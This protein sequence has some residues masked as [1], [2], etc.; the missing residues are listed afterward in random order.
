[1]KY[2]LAFLVLCSLSVQ[3]QIVYDVKTSKEGESNM[4]KLRKNLSN[5]EN[6]FKEI[7]KSKFQSAIPDSLKYISAEIGFDF[8]VDT[9]GAIILLYPLGGPNK[10]LDNL[11]TQSIKDMPRWQVINEDSNI[12]VL[13]SLGVNFP[14]LLVLPNIVIINKNHKSIDSYISPA[15]NAQFHALHKSMLEHN[16]LMEKLLRRPQPKYEAGMS[17]LLHQYFNARYE[18][19]RISRDTSIDAAAVLNFDVDAK[20]KIGKVTVLSNE[21]QTLTDFV[22]KKIKKYHKWKSIKPIDTQLQ[23]NYTL[24]VRLPGV[25]VYCVLESTKP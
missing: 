20:G 13:Y 18:K 9:N 21:N 23:G 17:D 11:I 14:Q 12:D 7:L 8:R 25:I 6:L 2:G 16:A 15:D 3:G 4:I 19:S 5:E 10:R 24:T 22:I 1:M